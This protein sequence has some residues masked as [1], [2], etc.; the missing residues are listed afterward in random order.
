[1]PTG[2]RTPS[3]RRKCALVGT[4]VGAVLVAG[5]SGNASPQER[6][7]SAPTTTGASSS[8]RTSPA[9]SPVPTVEPPPAAPAPA[10]GPAGQRAFARHVIDLWGFALRNNDAKPLVALGRGKPCGG[11]AALQRE[12]ARRAAQHWSVD[13]DGARL[14]RM[15]LTKRGTVQAARA[16]VDI[17]ASD[18]YNTD[19]TYRNT[20]PAHP[21]ATF[22]VQMRLAGGR[23]RLVAFTVS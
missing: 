19:G 3:L 4:V 22:E 7:P 11:C 16:T 2:A 13:F 21:G 5:C 20:N 17:P 14:R 15:T 10:K 8:A 1:M 18:S 23:Y 9:P 6:K 12:L